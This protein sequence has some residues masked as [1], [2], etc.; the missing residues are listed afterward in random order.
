VRNLLGA[1]L[2]V[3]TPVEGLIARVSAYRGDLPD[4]RVYVWAVSKPIKTRAFRTLVERMIALGAK[5]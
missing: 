5:K 4:T 3:F 2:T 1:R